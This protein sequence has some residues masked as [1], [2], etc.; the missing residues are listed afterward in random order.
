MRFKR[1]APVIAALMCV[2]LLT[3]CEAK[4]HDVRIVVPAG[5]QEAYAYSDAE[6]SPVR[7]QVILSSGDGLG[8][9]AVVLKPVEPEKEGGSVPTYMTPG[10]PVKL[11]AEKSVWYR[12]GVAVQNP[13]DEDIV[14]YVHVKNAELRIE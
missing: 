7:N 8:D 13:T 1:F 14:L 12:I 4:G 9:T 10:M 11:D 5:S 6:I 3:G 2:A